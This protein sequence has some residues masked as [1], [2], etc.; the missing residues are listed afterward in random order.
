MSGRIET[1]T[2]HFP[3]LDLR[4]T[5]DNNKIKM[6]PFDLI[7]GRGMLLIRGIAPP[8]H[9]TGNFE[10]NQALYAKGFSQSNSPTLNRGERFMPRDQEKQLA[11]N[12]FDLDINLN[13]NQGFFVRNEIIDAEFKGKARLIGFPEAPSLLGEGRLV[14]GKVLFKN[15]PF[16]FEAVKVEFDDPY[17][18]N[19]KF[20]ASAVSEVNQYK[21]RALVYGRADQW[22]AEFTSTPYLRENEIFA[23]LSSGAVS[24]DSGRFGSRDRSLVSQGEA[25][26]LILHSMDFSK[27]VQNKTGFQFDVEEAIDTQT[28]NSIFR[29]Q[30]LSENIASP[31][32]VLKRN[33]GRNVSFSLGSTV[34]MGSWNQKEVNAELKVTQ[35]MSMLGVWNNIE[36]VNTRESRTSFG[37]DLKFNRRFK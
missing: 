33:V 9:I 18:M 36:G 34:G 30:N 2:D 5:F 23:V 32:V 37:L 25:A 29:P 22:K 4:G 8:Y 14:Q 1:F 7:Q 12:L 21:I 27:D 24:A 20:N 11:S 31:K 28:A 3:E 16:I 26:S 6:D 13:A 10:V 19:P 35:G 17:R 15:R